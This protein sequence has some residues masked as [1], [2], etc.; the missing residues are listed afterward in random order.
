LECV[1]D[2]TQAPAPTSPPPKENR[3]SKPGLDVEALYK[4]EPIVKKIVDAFDGEITAE[5]DEEY[6]G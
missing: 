5:Q 1:I 2:E 6:V 3:T 4:K